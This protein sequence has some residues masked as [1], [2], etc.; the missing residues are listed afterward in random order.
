LEI[1]IVGGSGK[2]GNWF[3]HFLLRE[4]HKILLINRRRERLAPIQKNFDV[5]ISDEPESVK[6]ADI[7][8]FSVPIASFE[9]VISQYSPYIHT[10]Q[11]VIEITSVKTVPISA[12]HKYLNTKRVLGIHPMF[13]PGAHDMKGHNFI[14]TPTNEIEN[15]LATKARGFIEK[16][17]GNVSIMN[18]EEHDRLMAIVL[19][20]PHILALV[21]ADTL[22]KMGSFEQI[23]KLG[24]TT[25]KM[26]LMLADSVLT[27]D[28]GLYASIQTNIPHMVDF[29]MLLKKNVDEWVALVN[30]KDEK[31]FMER[32]K[33]LSELRK[34][35]DTTT[36]KA[37]DEMYR[38]LGK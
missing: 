15:E 5:D 23:E 18:P 37:Y 32:M 36:T 8:I 10:G 3:A 26:L 16:H 21:S 6:S 11:V 30:N 1:A 19:G 2:M 9:S 24:G 28:P 12:M 35:S 4:G 17:G 13:G 38:I 20:I 29:H 31:G 14:I 27:E 33:A 25:C 22:L 34:K 7:I